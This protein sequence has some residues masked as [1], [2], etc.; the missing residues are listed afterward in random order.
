ML[1]KASEMSPL[2]R[3]VC[4]QTATALT[5]QVGRDFV[6]KDLDL[7]RKKSIQEEIAHEIG[8]AIVSGKYV[9]GEQLG[10]EVEAS[11]R[12]KIS[13]PQYGEA[14]R[15]LQSKGLIEVGPG[16]GTRVLPPTD[17]KFL[18]PEVLQWL[19][20]SG[21]STSFIRELFE[22]RL[23]VEPAAAEFAATRRT[24]RQLQRMGYALEIMQRAGLN[25]EKGRTADEDFHRTILEAAHNRPLGAL[26]SSITAAVGLTT[27][28][29]HNVLGWSHDSMPVH[30]AVFDA[31]A[32]AA[33]EKARAATVELVQQAYRDMEMAIDQA[34]SPEGEHPN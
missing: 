31:I 29:K 16:T 1:A 15:I 2:L 13:R 27:F 14:S 21:T 12:L 32:E 11:E 3:Q 4:G 22:L 6:R 34:G 26:A 17:W 18:D 9:P 5:A 10:N 8:L 24:G 20:E 19:I 23:V 33:A 25:S 28:Y 30:Y 7:H